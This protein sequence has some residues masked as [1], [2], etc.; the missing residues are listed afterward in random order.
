MRLQDI[1]ILTVV[2][3]LC[4]GGV[5]RAAE[6]F[7][8]EYAH[9]GCESRV[10]AVSSGGPRER[11]LKREGVKVTVGGDHNVNGIDWT[12]DFVH[13]HSNGLSRDVVETLLRCAPNAIFAEQNVFSRPTAWDDIIHVSFQLSSQCQNTFERSRHEAM[14]FVVP[15]PISVSEFYPDKLGNESMRKKLGIP[16]DAVILGRVGQ[17]ILDKWGPQI[18]RTFESL[19][20]DFPDLWLVTVGAPE[21]LAKSFTKSAFRSRIKAINRIENDVDLRAINSMI[22]VFTHF[23]AQGESFGYV[24]CES[25][26]CATPVVTMSTPYADNSQGEVMGGGGIVATSSQEFTAAV[27]SLIKSPALRIEYG[28]VG[29]EHVINSYESS[30]VA[31]LALKTMLRVRSHQELNFYQGLCPTQL[32]LIRNFFSNFSRKLLPKFRFGMWRW[33]PNRV[34]TKIFFQ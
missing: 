12:P 20:R 15:N 26:L 11:N 14:S 23:A 27:R 18:L 17:P 31:D 4:L 29:R 13:L 19:A 3:S 9:L 32:G 6:N 5:E 2:N 30:L 1:K 25:L 21:L 33:L 28:Y 24:L 34:W 22:D 16:L 8:V 7:A 10:W